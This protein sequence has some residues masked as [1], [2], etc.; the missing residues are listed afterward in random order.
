MSRKI[1]L[2]F[3]AAA[4]AMMAGCEGESAGQFTKEHAGGL[5]GGAAGAGL[6]GVVGHAGTRS[7]GK[8]LRLLHLQ[9]RQSTS[10]YR[11]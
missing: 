3:M 9:Q 6:G 1:V 5:V 10:G 2:V 11:G 7:I 4:V 8:N